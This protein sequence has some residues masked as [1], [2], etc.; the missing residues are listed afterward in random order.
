MV[1]VDARRVAALVG[2]ADDQRVPI[3]RERDDGSEEVEG[4]GVGGLDIGLLRPV[5]IA[6]SHEQI[7]GTGSLGEA[8]FL[9]AV[10][11]CRAVAFEWGAD[12]HGVAVSRQRHA[13]PETMVG[14][15]VG[16][17]EVSDRLGQVPGDRYR[18]RRVRAHVVRVARADLVAGMLPEI[19]R[20]RQ[21]GRVRSDQ[22]RANLDE[23]RTV[24]DALEQP[25]MMV[26]GLRHPMEVELLGLRE[27]QLEQPIVGR[28]AV[29]I[30]RLGGLA[31]GLTV[32]RIGFVHTSKRSEEQPHRKS[33][34][35]YGKS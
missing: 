9:V 21:R 32:H 10:D 2:G 28:I 12:G 20:H 22:V 19:E 11:A 27:A 15:R 34:I 31:A 33:R 3:S 26:A 7:D 29:A 14:G 1:A 13:G 24:L 6:V 25:I 5:V 18:V 30:A 17:L 16:G 23:G 8:L 4:S 35:S